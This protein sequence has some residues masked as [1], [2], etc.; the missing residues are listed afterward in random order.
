MNID[1]FCLMA[2]EAATT[3]ALENS[4]NAHTHAAIKA[5]N[6]AQRMAQIADIVIDIKRHRD[7]EQR[8]LN[9]AF[10]STSDWVDDLLISNF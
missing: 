10:G 8:L 9:E 6:L 2:Q 7:E 3:S 1:N 4:F 5:G